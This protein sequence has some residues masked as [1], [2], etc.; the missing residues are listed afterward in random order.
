MDGSLE[1]YSLF[2][3]DDDGIALLDIK[4]SLE[5]EGATVITASS[6]AEG[7]ALSDRHY[8]AAILDIRLP[9]GD[10]F[11]VAEKLKRRKTHLIFCTANADASTLKEKFPDDVAISKPVQERV[12]IRAVQSAR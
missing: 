5:A 4:L 1:G 8:D 3:I 12:L 9:D 7:I 6:L 11:P 2:V 10:V